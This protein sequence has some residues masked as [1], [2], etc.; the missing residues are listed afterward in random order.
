LRNR[1]STLLTLSVLEQIRDSIKHFQPSESLAK[2]YAER[3][4][5]RQEPSFNTSN[6]NSN[7]DSNIS[8]ISS[9]SSSS[10]NS[11]Y[12]NLKHNDPPIEI[13]LVISGGGLK[14][15][16]MVGSAFILQQEFERHNIHIA[17]AA[18]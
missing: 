10:N 18:G 12:S 15:L 9:S 16:F 7:S 14:N 3:E 4:A 11:S 5:L 13:D 6:S 2:I 1:Q 8:S 17:R